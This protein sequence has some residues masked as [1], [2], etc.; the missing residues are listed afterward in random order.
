MRYA[1]RA[2]LLCAAGLVSV[3]ALARSVSAGPVTIQPGVTILTAN[4]IADLGGGDAADHKESQDTADLDKH[5]VTAHA[6]AQV[7]TVT[8]SGNVVADLLSR[9][10]G[11]EMTGT[12]ATNL[13][14]DNPLQANTTAVNNTLVPFTVSDGFLARINYAINIDSMVTNDQKVTIE[15]RRDG[16]SVSMF[17]QIYN[18]STTS[19]LDEIGPGSYRLLAVTGSL[20]TAKGVV[21]ETGSADYHVTVSTSQTDPP[22]AAIPLPSA[23]VPGAVTLGLVLLASR[24]KLRVR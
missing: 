12:A 18:K 13:P 6:Q 9:D 4:V 23:A 24:A 20:S 3:F 8:T 14:A 15:L 2:M 10:D 16:A 22:P 19:S 5:A 17:H 11:F 1:L 7:N 21:G